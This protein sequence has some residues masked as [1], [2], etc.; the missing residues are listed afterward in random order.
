MVPFQLSSLVTVD[1]NALLVGQDVAYFLVLLRA[2]QSAMRQLR[3]I[4]CCRLLG[5][6][7]LSHALAIYST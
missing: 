6:A 3:T 5:L 7:L 1:E 2:G 4:A